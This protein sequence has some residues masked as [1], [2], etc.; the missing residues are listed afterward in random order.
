MST[1]LKVFVLIV[2]EHA[3]RQSVP[4]IWAIFLSGCA[5]LSMYA[6]IISKSVRDIMRLIVARSKN[7]ASKN[8]C[9]S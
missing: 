2:F 1:P 4:Q 3:L 6:S 5:Y 9:A 7:E 8:L